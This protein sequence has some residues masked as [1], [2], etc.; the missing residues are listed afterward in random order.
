MIPDG[1]FTEEDVVVDEASFPSLFQ[2]EIRGIVYSAGSGSPE[3]RLHGSGRGF[4]L[5]VRLS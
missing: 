5:Q 1:S 4:T 2:G 3:D